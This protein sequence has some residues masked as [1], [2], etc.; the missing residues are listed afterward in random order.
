VADNQWQW[1]GQDPRYGPP[2]GYPVPPPPGGYPVP[3][4]GSVPPP[5]GYPGQPGGY[6]GQ[7]G[8][9]QV[10]MMPT[11]RASSADR[12]RTVDVLKAGFAEGRLTQDEYGERMGR[13]YSARTYG[14]L[15]AL[16]ADLP[17]GAVPLP[18]AGYTGSMQAYQAPANT[19]SLAIAAMVLGAAE[20]FTFGLTAI[21]A[22]LCGHLARK[23][24]RQARQS[25]GGL[26]T[27][28]LVLGY[29]AIIYWALRLVIAATHG[30]P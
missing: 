13:A 2:A 15:N 17:A 22:V 18:S 29:L 4:P 23:Q 16:I 20:V 3:P 14:E 19:N 8:G 12:E 28:G 11:M 27:G 24:I 26:A 21:P 10:R 5:A 9:Y 1:P 7:P 6:P 25:G 30:G